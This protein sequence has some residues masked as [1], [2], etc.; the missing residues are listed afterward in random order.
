MIGFLLAA[1]QLI[2]A[3]ELKQ[4]SQ[5]SSAD[6][7][8]E[9]AKGNVPP[10][11][12]A[13]SQWPLDYLTDRDEVLAELQAP[14]NK[15]EAH[16]YLG[17]IAFLL[18][19]A[20]LLHPSSRWL[21][22]PWIVLALL[23][24]LLATGLLILPLASM[25]GFSFFRYCGRYGLVTQLGVAVAAGLGVSAWGNQSLLRSV[26]APLLLAG[27]IFAEYFFVGHQVQYVT[28][29]DPPIIGL[30]DQSTFFRLL[31]PTDRVLAIDGNTLALSGAACVPPYL[32]M[33]PAEYYKTWESFPNIFTGAVPYDESIAR[34]LRTMGVSHLLTLAPLPTN[35]PVELLRSGYDPFLHPRWGRSPDE[36]LYLYRYQPHPGRAYRKRIDQ[37]EIADGQVSIREF[38]PHRVVIESEGD[39]PAELVLSDLL[40]PGWSVKVD[41]KETTPQPKA[42]VGRIVRIDAGKHVVEWIYHP[43]SLWMGLLVGGVGLALVAIAWRLWQRINRTGPPASMGPPPLSV[44]TIQA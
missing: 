15:V 10:A 4:L 2:P 37:N 5:R 28:I 23:M 7:L 17:P 25:P 32:G 29:V 21:A 6:F 34:T 1:P 43:R 8:S 14:T 41:G 22:L 20:S 35:W 12:F 30:R 42:S 27:V 13:R 38:S 31:T 33:G 3:W 18:L 40:F 11:Y 16:L 9:I 36:P 44:D 39:S 24:G 19:I 26:L